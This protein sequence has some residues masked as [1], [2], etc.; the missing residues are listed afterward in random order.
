M[1]EIGAYILNGIDM[2]FT[3][4]DMVIISKLPFG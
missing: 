1:G 4:I 3:G 2:L